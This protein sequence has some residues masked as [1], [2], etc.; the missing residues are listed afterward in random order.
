LRVLRVPVL[1][2]RFEPFQFQL[3]VV[4]VDAVDRVTAGGGGKQVGQE[5]R[6]AADG[7]RLSVTREVLFDVQHRRTTSKVVTQ[8]QAENGT[9]CWHDTRAVK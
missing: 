2:D 3:R 9:V 7:Q 4:V 5:E 8:R 6:V 1:A